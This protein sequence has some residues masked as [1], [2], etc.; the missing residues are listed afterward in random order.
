MVS[1]ITQENPAIVTVDAEKRHSYE[2]G[3]FVVFREV[4]GMKEINNQPPMMI[5]V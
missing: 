5:K 2:D 1:S 4:E 3:D